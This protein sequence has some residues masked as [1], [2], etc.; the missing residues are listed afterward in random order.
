ML[1]N[2]VTSIGTNLIFG[3]IA[4]VGIG[5]IIAFH[6]FGHFLFCKL[7]KIRTPSFSIGFGP[8]LITKK[9]GDTEFALSAIPVGGYVEIAGAA[10]VGQGEQLEAY[11]SDEHSFKNKPWYQKALVMLGGILFNLMF[12][13]FTCSL[14][15]MIGMPPSIMLYPR[16]AT[17]VVS[18]VVSDSPAAKA[19][20]QV[21]DTIISIN[22]QAIAEDN[23]QQ[24][25]ETL[26]A[27]ANTP[28]HLQVE[29]NG[30]QLGIDFTPEQ[31]EFLGKKVGS[32]G[33]GL[34]M[35]SLPPVPFSKAISEGIALTNSIMKTTV[36][37]FRHIF[38]S[39]DTSIVGGPIMIISQSMKHTQLG[40]KNF[41]FFL[42]YL[43]V[44]LAI[45]NIIPLPIL[46]GGQLLVY[47][48]EAIIGHSI[49]DRVREYIHIACWIGFLALLILLSAQDLKMILKP[50]LE[51]IYSFFGY[52]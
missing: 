38:S 48:I 25:I 49:P 4:L 51:H 45:L 24:L 41:L 9:I 31:K 10:E 15:F 22:N 52:K 6:E 46:D 2:T 28:V 36:S 21:N 43:S 20:L 17:P 16:N 42:A 7:F 33:I 11:S 5:F 3:L 14:L 39:G 30:Q 32:S 12:A 34:K 13:Y 44:S 1:T 23:A 37:I 29:R 26:Q 8:R 40:F 19:G 50:Y 35:R 27:A 47:T 18:Q